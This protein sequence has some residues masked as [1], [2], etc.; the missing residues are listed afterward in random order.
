MVACTQNSK[1][2]GSSQEFQSCL[3]HPKVPIFQLEL[4]FL[5]DASASVGETNFRVEL[6]FARKLLRFLE[7][8]SASVRAAIVTFAGRG[9]IVR[10]LDHVSGP[11][12]DVGGKCRSA[13]L[14]LDNVSYTGGGTYTYGALMEALVGI[15]VDAPL[16]SHF[17]NFDR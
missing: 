7:A 9:Q 1:K 16:L 12:E 11:A 6:S 10:H 17:P 3:I 8:E 4:V 5:I 14:H 13:Q 2:V 15:L